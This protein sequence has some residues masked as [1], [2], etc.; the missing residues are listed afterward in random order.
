LWLAVLP[1]RPPLC[2]SPPLTIFWYQSFPLTPSNPHPL[3]EGF[4]HLPKDVPRFDLRGRRIPIH[5]PSGEYGPVTCNSSP[6]FPR[7]GGARIGFPRDVKA[8]VFF[9]F[10]IPLSM[11][12]CSS[13]T[14]TINFV[15]LRFRL[16]PS[17]G[18]RL[19]FYFFREGKGAVLVSLLIS[20][21][22]GPV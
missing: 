21:F 2:L 3:G 15:F 18:M 10:S 7:Q 9:F 6:T 20:F 19:V 12:P 17:I 5:S 4:I 16:F 1:Y 13:S 14:S 11:L 22:P 8:L